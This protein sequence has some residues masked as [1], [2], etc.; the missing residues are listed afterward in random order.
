VAANFLLVGKL[1]TNW[2][3]FAAKLCT[4]ALTDSEEIVNM[5]QI[6]GDALESA[7]GYSQRN[8]K[9]MILQGRFLALLREFR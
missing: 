1:Y 9:F 8:E 7:P 5:I 3:P 6:V 4:F 2:Q